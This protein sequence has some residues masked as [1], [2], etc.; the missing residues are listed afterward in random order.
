MQR[1]RCLIRKE[2][3]EL[4]QNPRL[5]GLVIIAP[6]IQLTLLGYAATT[7][8]KD[9]PV[10]VADGD[11]SPA[12]RELIARFDGSK[13][14]RI[15]DTVTTV[16]DIDPWLQ[17]GRAWI[18]LSIPPHYGELVRSGRGATV[19]IV[20]DGS[21]AN[22]TTVALGYATALIGAYVEEL[23][24]GASPQGALRTGGAIDARIRVWFNPQLESRV[25]MVPG[26]L[27]L[28]LLLITANLAAMGI[29]R[30]KELGTLE[31]LNVTPLRRWE[32]IV[33]KLLPYGAIAVVDVLLVTA[34]AIFWF[35]V[36]L[37]GSFWLLFGMSLLYLLCTLGL[38]LFIS[39]ISDTQQQAMMTA[40]FFFLTPMIYLS[41]FIFP[42]ENMPRVIQYATYVIPLRYFLVIVRGIFLKG[43]GL[44][45]LWP[46]AAAMTAW[47]VVVLALAVA[48]SRK[49]SA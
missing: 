17:R 40:T 1:L 28:L 19:Q 35:E 39:T 22:S 37:R 23:V 10:V 41:G 47:G 36:P 18:A 49:R 9:V 2:F 46:Q 43:L 20:A 16:A 4:R 14:F 3:L 48:R 33:G 42:I 7:D 5:F 13:N 34:V 44:E 6:I 8:V 21:D 25:F 15:I 24:D 38:G 32:L 12:S 30:E 11:R 26:V 31:Q 27:A 45:L 29:V